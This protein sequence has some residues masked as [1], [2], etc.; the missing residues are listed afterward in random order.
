M[1]TAVVDY[2][3]NRNGTPAWIT[4]IFI[5][6]VVCWNQI[7]TWNSH[8]FNRTGLS[9]EPSVV[10]TTTFHIMKSS[11]GG[12]AALAEHWLHNDRQQPP[13][14][15]IR[16]GIYNI[17]PGIFHNISTRETWMWT[18]TVLQQMSISFYNI[19][20]YCDIYVEPYAEVRSLTVPWSSRLLPLWPLVNCT[21][22]RNPYSSV[23]SQ[24]RHTVFKVLPSPALMVCGLTTWAKC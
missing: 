23:L 2:F 3:N 10:N 12:W 15:H 5:L 24:R 22:R 6:A 4:K 1:N 7:H 8:S 16:A 11:E 18:V 14:F 13:A 17:S 19:L 21:N 9:S 20:I